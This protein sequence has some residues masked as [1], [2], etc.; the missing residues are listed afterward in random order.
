MTISL[1]EITNCTGCHACYSICPK[2][3]ISMKSNYEGFLYP[4]VDEKKCI[5]CGFCRKVCPALNP[6][7]KENEEP[8]AYAAINKNETVRVDSSSGGIFSAIADLIINEG[9]VVFGAKFSKDF[10]VV[11]QWV[12][13]KNELSSLR[14]SKY[15][16]SVIGESYKNC[17]QFLDAGREVLFTGTPCQIQGLKKFLQ[18]EYDK[19]FCLDIICHGIPSPLLWKK[20][21]NYREKKSASQTVTTAFRRKYHGWKLY[22]L[23]FTFENA[24]EYKVPFIKDP[25]M[26]IFLKDIALR[27]SC[28]NCFSRG[29][30]RSSDI[31][32]GDF[33][34]IQNVL[35]D[36]DDDKGTC[37]IIVHS[38]KGES[39]IKKLN[40]CLIM[41]VPIND[42][43]K[44][45][46][47]IKVSPEVPE[48]R[49]DFYC[50][51]KY[52]KFEQIIKQY[53][54]RPLLL[55]ICRFCMRNIR[56][57]KNAFIGYRI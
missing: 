2:S 8:Q 7:L 41:E 56:K 22:S 13:N 14:G 40:N 4:F 33:W 21:I 42:A 30:K 37:F 18:K 19:L 48:Q 32:L 43:V 20:Y 39:L 6:I 10:S 51:L 35:P 53:C 15:L 16:E 57:L 28:Y 45:N 11:H 44:Y 36:M 47:S 34:G 25:Y 49:L 31:T 17:K 50:D 3:A 46:L 38:E 12:D 23:A 54:K 55:R 29:I 26:Q 52:K 27:S 5:D 24:S 9:G 1:S